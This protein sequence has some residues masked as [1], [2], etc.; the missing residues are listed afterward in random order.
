DSVMSAPESFKGFVRR[1]PVLFASLLL[2]VLSMFLVPPSQK[3]IDYIDVRTLAILLCLMAVVAGISSTGAFD[4]LARSFLKGNRGIRATSAV[5]VGLPFFL[6][7]FIT[8]DVSLITFVP[9]AIVVLGMAG[10][11]DLIIP[12][13]VLQTLAANL[14]SM[15]LP[16]GNPQNIFIASRYGVDLTDFL[17][18]TGPYVAIGGL[19]LAVMLFM[20]GGGGSDVRFDDGPGRTDVRRLAVFLILFT[21]SVCAVLRMLPYTYVLT[22]VMAGMLLVAPRV[23]VKVDWGLLLTFVFLFVFAGNISSIDVVRDALGGLMSWDTVI[24]SAFVSQFVSNVPA[25]VMLSN[26]TGDWAGLLAGV[27]IGGFG[28]PIASMASII[29]LRICSMES[30]ADRK[31]FLI[32]F[33]VSNIVMLS[34]LI[35][36]S[37]MF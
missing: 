19:V 6:S 18:T 16:F 34:V 15:I 36:F 32:L 28:T 7:M 22:I 12:V 35:L 8:N 30:D 13:A 21:V 37:R 20:V 9:F 24:S 29:T 10:R 14:G 31:R 23:L 5:L 26:F 3:Y 27:N 33:I 25:A 4:V 1:D 17:V 11:R 2:A